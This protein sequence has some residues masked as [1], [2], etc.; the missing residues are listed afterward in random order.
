MAN[1]SSSRKKSAKF[2]N[3]I[4]TVDVIIKMTSGIVLIRRKNP[5]EGWA[6]PGGF[7]D[8]GE[9]LETAAQREALEETGLTITLEEQFHTYSDPDRDPRMH[10]ITTVFTATA[11]GTPTGGDDAAEAAVFT[12][13][14]LPPLAFDHGAILND[15]FKSRP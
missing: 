5:P 12:Q 8:Y 10:T 11:E 3:P 7:V 2:R 9:S 1:C 6:L 4:P 13:D 14:N 15:Y